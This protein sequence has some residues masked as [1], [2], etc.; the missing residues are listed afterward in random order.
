MVIDE[1]KDANGH[2]QKFPRYLIYDIVKYKNQDV[3]QTDFERRILCIKKEIIG[4]RHTY[5]GEVFLVNDN[6]YL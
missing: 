6:I 3:G 5:I 4:A 1:F 2:E